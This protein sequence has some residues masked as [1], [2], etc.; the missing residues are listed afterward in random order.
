MAFN[1]TLLTE[2]DKLVKKADKKR[3]KRGDSKFTLKTR[4]PKSP[5]HCPKPADAPDWTCKPEF[6]TTITN[7]TVNISQTAPLVESTETAC[8]GPS[9]TPQRNPTG[10]AVARQIFNET[11]SS[12]SSESSSYH[13]SDS[14]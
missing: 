3:L 9:S 5:S 10:G 11:G 7:S 12:S 6:Q 1:I 14:E 2:L 13:D 8:A 4:I